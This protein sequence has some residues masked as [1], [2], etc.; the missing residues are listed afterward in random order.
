MRWLVR[1]ASAAQR[2]RLL[3]AFERFQRACPAHEP[4]KRHGT[5]LLATLVALA[6]AEP[7]GAES[8]SQAREVAS[9]L[10]EWCLGELRGWLDTLAL[11][12]VPSRGASARSAQPT[13]ALRAMLAVARAARACDDD[14]SCAPPSR[15]ADPVATPFSALATAGAAGVARAR[16]RGALH[17]ALL[18]LANGLEVRVLRARA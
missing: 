3:S 4:A 6:V 9:L 1:V 8:D 16:R 17:E 12:L 10:S 18:G 13:V 14:N 5:R 15:P 7:A 2:R 11:Q